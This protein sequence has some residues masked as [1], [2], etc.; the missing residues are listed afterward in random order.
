MG[1]SCTGTYQYTPGLARYDMPED[2]RFVEVPPAG[3]VDVAWSQTPEGAAAS[4]D[5]TGLLFMHRNAMVERESDH[6][7]ITS[8]YLPVIS[9]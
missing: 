6:I 3:A 2:D 5:Q 7:L 9:R 4:P 8:M 1:D